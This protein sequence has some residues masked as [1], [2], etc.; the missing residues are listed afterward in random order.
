MLPFHCFPTSFLQQGK[1]KTVIHEFT[2]CESS[3]DLVQERIVTVDQSFSHLIKDEQVEM[4]LGQY[5]YC[6]HQSIYSENGAHT[7]LNFYAFEGRYCWLYYVRVFCLVVNTYSLLKTFATKCFLTT[8]VKL[9]RTWNMYFFQMRCVL[10]KILGELLDRGQLTQA[11]RLSQLFAV[12]TTD[13]DI[14]LVRWSYLKMFARSPR[15]LILMIF[16]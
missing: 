11:R 12:S 7:I 13:L 4:R 5:I 9:T 10:R 2:F 1:S 3:S 6:Q 15:A 8:L 16:V 14:V